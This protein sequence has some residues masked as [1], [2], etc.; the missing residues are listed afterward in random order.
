MT[1]AEYQATLVDRAATQAA[2]EDIGPVADAA[3]SL[4]CPG[5]AP[6]WP[7]DSA[8]AALVRRPTGD[9]VFNYPSSMLFAPVVTTP[10][11]SVGSMPVGV[12]L[13]GMQHQDARMAAL[14]RWMRE[15]IPPVVA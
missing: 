1:P 13:I 9:A 12:Q 11:I 4:S 3:I 8:G 6:L 10:M 5:P 15:Y 14:G 2:H 7:G